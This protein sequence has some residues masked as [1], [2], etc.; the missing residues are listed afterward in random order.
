MCKQT[1]FRYEDG[2]DPAHKVTSLLQELKSTCLH[3]PDPKKPGTT[4]L[5]PVFDGVYANTDSTSVTVMI[6]TD[7]VEAW[8]VCEKISKCLFP[9]LCGHW[10]SLVYSAGMTKLLMEGMRPNTYDL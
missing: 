9:W 4:V 7:R 1:K 8:Y 6:V 5:K 3:V 2:K 10:G